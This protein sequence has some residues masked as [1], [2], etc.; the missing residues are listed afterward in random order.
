MFPAAVCRSNLQATDWAIYSTIEHNGDI[1][2]RNTN[3]N[4]KAQG[5]SCVGGG[6]EGFGLGGGGCIYVCDLVDGT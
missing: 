2:W 4:E 1:F 5:S 3:V 6:G